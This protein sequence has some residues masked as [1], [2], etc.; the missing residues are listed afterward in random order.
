[1]HPNFIHAGVPKAASATLEGLFRAHPDIFVP[2]AKETN[3][4]SR[5]S[6]FRKGIT[7]YLERY[8]SSTGDAS[9]IADLS[10]GYSTGLAVEAPKRIYECL[11]SEIKLLFVFRHP[12]ERAYSQY[13]MAS[14]KGQI[15]RLSFR[16]SIERALSVGKE[17][18]IRII[19]RIQEG[20]YYSS[21]KDMDIYRYCMYIAPGLYF[22][23]LESFLEY[24]DK[25]N[26]C[27][28][29]TE[30]LAQDF[31]KQANRV[32]NFLGINTIDVSDLPRRNESQTLR[33]PLVRR[34]FNVLMKSPE[35]RSIAYRL[36]RL[37]TGQNLKRLLF[38]WNYSPA[39]STSNLEGSTA[40][41]LNQFYG[42]EI[43]A[44]GQHLD[45]RDLSFWKERY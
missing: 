24:F 9:V 31:Q 23:I 26:V 19:N 43:T 4:F 34:A 18:D 28:L 5:D 12:V 16:D 45:G 33:F 36:L 38:R 44:L 6:D 40:G 32:F 42:D 7:W 21:V 11:G 15:D 10:V 14:N 29:L 37:Q 27:I 3:F 8:Y 41:V 2:R 1:M 13:R 35:T 30:D 17:F 22:S 39:T 25:T 20:S